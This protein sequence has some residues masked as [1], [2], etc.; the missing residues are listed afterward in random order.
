MRERLFVKEGQLD[1]TSGARACPDYSGDVPLS[2]RMMLWTAPTL[3]HRCAKG[4][5]RQSATTMRG[6]VHGRS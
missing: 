6:A 2:S 5:L 3:R 4:W 1:G